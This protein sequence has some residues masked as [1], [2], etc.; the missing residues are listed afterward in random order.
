M[1]HKEP[2]CNLRVK[3]VWGNLGAADKILSQ[4]QTNME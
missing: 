3:V 2:I 4:L 1:V